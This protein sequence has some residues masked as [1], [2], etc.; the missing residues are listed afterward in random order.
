MFCLT[1][2]H[3]K[4][5]KHRARRWGLFTRRTLFLQS[6]HPLGHSLPQCTGT[7]GLHATSSPGLCPRESSVPACASGLVDWKGPGANDPGSGLQPIH[8]N[9]WINTTVSSA[10]LGVRCVLHCHPEFPSRTEAWLPSSSSP[11]THPGLAPFASHLTP[12]LLSLH[13]LKSL[14]R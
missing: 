1:S 8:R 13:F 5:C 12:S 6:P 11:L 10:L 3:C 14:P 4:F 9:W 7:H 2:S